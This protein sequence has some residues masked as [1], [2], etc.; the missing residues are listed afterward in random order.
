M[1]VRCRGFVGKTV[2]QLLRGAG[3]AGSKPQKAVKEQGEE[4]E[5]S[6]YWLCLQRKENGRQD[7]NKG[8]QL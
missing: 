8:S 2:V 5:K 4:D 3:M 7:P 1:K 6:S